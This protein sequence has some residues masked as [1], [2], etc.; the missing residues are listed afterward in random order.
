MLTFLRGACLA[1]VVVAAALGA[2]PS[3]QVILGSQFRDRLEQIA[4]STNGV[5]GIAAIDLTSGD[6]F[7]VNDSLVFPQGSAIKIPILIELFRR[8][9]TG[10]LR[11]DERVVLRATDQVGGSG[12]S[13]WF[14]DGQSALS[15]H[16]LA[17]LMI[18]LSDNT[19]TNILIDRLGM[20]NVNKAMD[21]FGL[22]SIR[23]QRKMI[24]P[25]ESAVGNENVATPRDAARLMRRIHTCELP[26]TKER[27][28]ELRR[29]L[30][31]PKAG[32]FPASVPGN[33]RVAW[34]PGGVEGVETAWGLFA[35]AGRPYVLAVMV[36]YSDSPE[37]TRAL[38]ES[39][40]AAYEYFR[41]LARSSP[42]GVRVPLSVADSV[43]KP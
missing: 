25:R 10:T 26:M 20:V 30:E 36:N 7:G 33:V 17:V 9:E 3:H 6:R 21:D 37:S 35:L 13:Q 32:P 43:R 41:R 22:T 28:G 34:K 42:Y 23:V 4:K 38:R 5:V 19:A 39:A 15:L 18:T 2:Q 12:V 31:L 16:D 11:P 27:C 29:I 14:G 24:Q 40:Q 8:F 1:T